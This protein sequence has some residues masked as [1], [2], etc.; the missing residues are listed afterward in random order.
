S[1]IVKDL[2]PT[3]SKFHY[4]FNLRDLSR[5]YNGLVST[6]PER[7]QTAAQLTRVWRNECLRVLYDR[8]IDSQDRKM[9]DDKLSQLINDQPLLKPHVEYI[10]RQPSLYG[11][12]R[13]ALDIGE[14]RIY[15][16]IQDYDAAKALFEEILQEYNEQYTRMNLVL[17]DDALEHLTRIHRVI[18]MDKGNALLVGVGGSG[19]SSLTRL[20]AFAAGCEV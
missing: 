10:F 12:Y 2:P 20:A 16:D 19:K 9:V 11:D 15:E 13:T 18:R 5:I 8:L 14:A 1:S 3:P 4:I 17:F 6:I 7:F